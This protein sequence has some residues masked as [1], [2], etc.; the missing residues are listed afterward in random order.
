[1]EKVNQKAG[2]HLK[3][4]W[5]SKAKVQSKAFAHMLFM[6]LPYW[7]IEDHLH[8]LMQV[9]AAVQRHRKHLVL[10]GADWNEAYL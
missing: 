6:H 1:L 5:S 7:Q 2:D 9:P 3:K 8:W 10:H 4:I